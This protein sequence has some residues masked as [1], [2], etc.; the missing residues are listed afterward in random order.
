[1]SSKNGKQSAAGPTVAVMIL[2]CIAAVALAAAVFNEGLI[3]EQNA[4]SSKSVAGR[5]SDIENTL[6]GMS[7]HDKV[8]Q[9]IVASPETLTDVGTATAAGQRTKDALARYPVGGIILFANNLENRNQ[10]TQMIADM[11]NYARDYNG[12]GL[13]IS[14]DEEGGNVARVAKKLG[15]SAFK[16]MYEYRGEG[17][18]KAYEN[19]AAIAGSISG[20]GFNLNFAPV[21]D[22]WSNPK[23]EV[24]GSR[25]YSDDFAQTA[26]LV[27]S[28]VNGFH[29]GSV[30]CTLKHFPGHGDTEQ[31][32]HSGSAYSYKSLE[33]LRN[34]EFLPFRAGIEAGADM[35][36]VGHISLPKLD[37][38]PASLSS[39]I[40]E[41]ILRAELGYD[42]VV[43]TDSLSMGALTG[44]YGEAKIAVMAVQAGNDILLCQGGMK[45]MV[46]AVENAAANGEITEERINESV[47]R[48][49]T[50]KKK[51]GLLYS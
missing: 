11:Q 28:A 36:M 9:M 12:I 40:I 29:S 6:N 41:D 47:R 4:N 37:S 20:F 10:T 30:M 45:T 24:I 38:L 17:A 48:I 33:E 21:A 16:P 39:V 27:A 49:L 2:V 26:E 46:A 19:A 44:S 5:D 23:N 1:M 22:T 31:D 8:C 3:K 18:N 14:V 7:L 13:F 34:E 42:G 15:T 51:Y 25:A 35:V 43:I 50:L 32:S